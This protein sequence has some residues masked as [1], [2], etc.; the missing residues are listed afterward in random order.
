M[1]TTLCLF[2]VLTLGAQA[3]VSSPP[4]ESKLESRANAYFVS[5]AAGN[6][7]RVCELSSSRIRGDTDF[8]L[9]L[10]VATMTQMAPYNLTFELHGGC[11]LDSEGWVFLKM[12]ILQNK[13]DAWDD[14]AYESHWVRVEDEW[15]LDDLHEIDSLD[16]KLKFCDGVSSSPN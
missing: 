12:Q 7:N 3:S 10:F 6:F 8:G 13:T 5:L 4:L 11:T 16:R 15:Y 9:D 14:R 2:A 1:R